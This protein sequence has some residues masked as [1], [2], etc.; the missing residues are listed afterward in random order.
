MTV[1]ALVGW[2]GDVNWTEA[3]YATEEIAVQAC[4][5]AWKTQR[6][7]HPSVPDY[8]QGLCKFGVEEYEVIGAA[9]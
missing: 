4:E 2:F 7:K 6:S 1:Y 3:I 5:E 9:S 8:V